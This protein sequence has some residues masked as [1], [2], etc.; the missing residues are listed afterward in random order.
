MRNAP[1]ELIF[2]AANAVDIGIFSLTCYVKIGYYGFMPGNIISFILRISLVAAFWAFTW[3]FVEPRTRLLRILRA[4]MLV[5]G[6][7][8]M[9]ALLRLTRW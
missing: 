7:L 4:A 1:S 6:L 3:Q 5:V 8:F 9:L 2:R